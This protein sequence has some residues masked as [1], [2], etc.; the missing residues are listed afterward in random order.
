MIHRISKME[1]AQIR[2]RRKE[3]EARAKTEG[4][5]EQIH[6]IAGHTASP[7]MPTTIAHTENRTYNR[8]RE[9]RNFRKED[10]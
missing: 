1:A 4:R 9:K 3:A 2:K 10:W 6:L 7:V 5:I 8:S